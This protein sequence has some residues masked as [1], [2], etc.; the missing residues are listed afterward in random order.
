[1]PQQVTNADGQLGLLLP[2]NWLIEDV[3][4]GADDYLIFAENSF[5]QNTI[6]AQLEEA[7]NI[8]AFQGSA[9]TLLL[10]EGLGGLSEENLDAYLRG[11]IDE[12][13]AALLEDELFT[14]PSDYADTI[15]AGRIQ[16][17]DIQAEGYFVVLD[18]GDTLVEMRA[19]SPV[20]DFDDEGALL[21]NIIQS[22]RLDP[23][24]DAMDTGDEMDDMEEDDEDAAVPAATEEAA[25]DSAVPP[26]SGD[27]LDNTLL[28]IRGVT[29]LRF[30][31]VIPAEGGGIQAYLEVNV[32]EEFNNQETAE[33]LFDAAL[34][35]AIAEYGNEN[36]APFQFNAVLWDGVGPAV[37][38]EWQ[39][40]TESWLQTEQAATPAPSAPTDIEAS[41]AHIGSSSRTEGITGISLMNYAPVQHTG[42]AQ[43]GPTPTLGGTIDP[44]GEIIIPPLEPGSTYYLQIPV[45]DLAPGEYTLEIGG[46]TITF[47]LPVESDLVA[48]DP[49]EITQSNGTT[50]FLV[51]VL[52]GGAP[53]VTPTPTNTL[54]PG[55]TPSPSA[56]LGV[57]LTISVTPPDAG[58]LSPFDMT[59]TALAGSPSPTILPEGG[60]F[61]DLGDSP[62]SSGLALL[63]FLGAGLVA[64]VVVARRLRSMV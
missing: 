25:S 44:G 38:W 62:S 2:E 42:Y 48:L 7:E 64:V 15:Q 32:A 13:G 57:T 14:I 27:V 21:L 6:T 18:F 12:E 43:A 47:E 33:A 5:A 23:E 20:T 45:D 16:E 9:G 28:G 50:A 8:T 17:S 53:D 58:T 35:Y 31:S 60:F 39:E 46:A 26:A 3:Q 59:A 63:A 1:L 19:L 49:V 56:T 61:E 52:T 55:V 37:D 54:A 22:V 41:G 34:N 36:I 10:I 51:L 24:F 40:E 30:T 11:R 4:I 29:G